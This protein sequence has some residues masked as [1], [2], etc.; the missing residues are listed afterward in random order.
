MTSRQLRVS[1]QSGDRSHVFICYRR[2]DSRASAGR[3][4]D[5]LD[6]E[7][8]MGSIFK[9]VD[10]IDLGVD[11]RTAVNNAISTCS[12]MIVV[13]GEKWLA[14]G[15]GSGS[16]L[17]EKNDYVRYEIEQAFELDLAIFPVLVDGATLPSPEVLPESI[18]QLAYLNAAVLEHDAW[19]P[20][21]AQLVRAIQAATRGQFNGI[22][23]VEG[24]A[25]PDPPEGAKAAAHL[26]WSQGRSGRSRDPIAMAEQTLADRERVLGAEHP[27]TVEAR[28]QLAAV[29]RTIGRNDEADQL[30]GTD[31]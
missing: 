5:L 21:T 4:Y 29:Y 3:L 17:D 11:F 9:D 24:F 27:E 12:A 10:S 14:G 30:G 8:G 20:T 23:N 13:I 16:R 1:E 6:G 15:S 19:R 2:D 28:T 26:S 25:G 31:F 22:A 18:R 7:I